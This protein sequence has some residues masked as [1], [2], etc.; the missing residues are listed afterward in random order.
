[1]KLCSYCESSV[2]TQQCDDCERARSAEYAFCNECIQIH[3]KIKKYSNHSHR[4]FNQN[5]T[6]RQAHATSIERKHSAEVTRCKA[7]IL[8]VR[9]TLIDK[10]HQVSRSES[11]SKRPLGNATVPAYS[12]SS[13]SSKRRSSSLSLEKSLSTMSEIGDAIYDHCSGLMNFTD[14]VEMLNFFEFS[15]LLRDLPTFS[16]VIPMIFLAIL[17]LVFVGDVVK[18]LGPS[19]AIVIAVIAFLR[20]MQSRKDRKQNNDVGPFR[21][22]PSMPNMQRQSSRTSFRTTTRRRQVSFPQM[23]VPN[24][25]ACLLISLLTYLSTHPSIHSA[26]NPLIYILLSCD[27]N[28]FLHKF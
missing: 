25:P 27:Q 17:V 23:K 2:A 20:V 28:F 12:P 3:Q 7:S 13:K 21:R 6:P 26:I 11:A 10:S 9:D 5:E 16:A 24:T 18:G 14:V 15:I 1:M 4:A 22:G 19:V 8:P